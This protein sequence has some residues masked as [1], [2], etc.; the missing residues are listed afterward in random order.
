MRYV[1]W[2]V[3]YEGPSDALY[4]DILLPRA[5]RELIASEGVA[6]ADIP[7]APA[8][9]LGRYGREVEK[10]AREACDARD[11]FDMIFV[12]AD[13]GGRH[14]ERGLEQRSTAYCDAFQQCCDWPEER[15]VTVSPRHETEAWLLADDSAVASALGYRGDRQAL[16]LP[17]DA[18]AADRLPDPKR[19]LTDAI[20]AVAGRRRSQR[21]DLL[22]PAIAQRQSLDRLR[23]SPSFQSFR[24]RLRTCLRSLGHVR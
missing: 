9:R 10:V 2:A 16:G 4:L 17:A 20:A 15:C 12:H 21:V 19:T 11:A 14:L 8:V 1:S 6:L 13:T 7:D 22:F 5:I 18:R 24:D 23:G 3:M